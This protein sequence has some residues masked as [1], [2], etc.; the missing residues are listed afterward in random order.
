MGA[1][2][3]TIL[4][5]TLLCYAQI[6]SSQQVRTEFSLN[7]RSGSAIV[8]P[9]LAD[10]A[11]EISGIADFLENTASDPSAEVTAVR[12]FG[13]TSPEGS[14]QFNRRLAE[15]RVEAIERIVRAKADIPENIISREYGIPWENLKRQIAGSGLPQGNAI[16]EIIGDTSG[17]VSYSDGALVD[18]RVPGL[19]KLGDGTAWELLNRKYFDKMRAARVTFVTTI[20]EPSAPPSLA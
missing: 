14:N 4:F 7:F 3:A 11:A 1:R 12:F 16:L 19:K 8:E 9:G 13:N 10:N 20:K 18:E 15:K 17:A 6:A 5:F 2:Q